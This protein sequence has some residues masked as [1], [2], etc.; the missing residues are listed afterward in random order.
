MSSLLII[1]DEPKMTEVL[2]R[3]LS[4]EGHK[5]E[6]TSD[7][8]Q[9]LEQL[10]S[11]HFDIILCDLKMPEISGIDVLERAKRISPSTDFVIMTAYATAQTA[12]EAMKKG[13]FDYLIKPFPLDELKLLIHRIEETK[14]LKEENQRLKEVIGQTFNIENIVAQSKQMQDVLTRAR[15]VAQSNASVL[16]RGESGT[17]KEVLAKAI[18]NMSTRANGPLIVANCGA[19]PEN[20]LESEF[21]GHVK[22][23]FTGAIETRKGMF[24]SA[25]GGSI[26][27]DEIGEVPMHLQVK[28][29]RVL[30]EGEIQ[31]VGESTTRKVDVR[32]IAA[33]NRNLE[34]GV[35]H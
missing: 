34:E 4:R 6:F 8:A 27:L 22:G 2:A 21:F 11:K 16:L 1:D 14:N 13:A 19:I 25:N 20:L 28:L 17:G 9:G 5:V 18:H 30:Q 10:G 29:L 26:F 35:K 24:E 12:V 7:P 3:M 33:T 15:K 31:R 23:S 32:I